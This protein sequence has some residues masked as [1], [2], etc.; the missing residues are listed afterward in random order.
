MPNS[1]A[2]KSRPGDESRRQGVVDFSCNRETFPCYVYYNP[3]GTLSPQTLE[4][5]PYLSQ[6]F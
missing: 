2:S 5:K 3:I 1:G 4:V 6:G